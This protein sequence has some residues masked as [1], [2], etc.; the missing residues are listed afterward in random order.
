M[1]AQWIAVVFLLCGTAFSQQAGAN[2]LSPS[3][4]QIARAIDLGFQAAKPPYHA[5]SFDPQKSKIGTKYLQQ[6]N[7]TVVTP[8]LCSFGSGLNA[9]NGLKDKPEVSDVKK[10]CFGKVIVVI[11]HISPSRNA[12]WPVVLERAGERMQ[13]TYSLPDNSPVSTRYTT[14][15]GKQRGYQ[16]ED[17][18]IFILSEAWEAGFKLTYADDSGTHHDL[19]V[20]TAPFARDV[21]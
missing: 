8:L 11:T 13:P 6:P 17:R 21:T 7:L 15:F 5:F 3:D 4:E 14:P 19:N 12:N 16:Y 1:S 9:H 2:W 10:A 18:Y 20:E